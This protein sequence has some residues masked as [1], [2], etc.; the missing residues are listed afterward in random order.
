MLAEARRR[1]SCD[2]LL[3]EGDMRSFSLDRRFD[4]VICLF[5]SIGYMSSV[6]ELCRAANTMAE[7]LAPGGILVLDGWVRP[8]NWIEPGTV[9]VVLAEKDGL[10]VVR[11][12]RSRREGKVALLEMHHLV[13]TV[14]GIDHLVD[15]HA[16]TLFTPTEYEGALA[17]A[18]LGF[19]VM[20]SP[21]PGRDRYVA[22]RRT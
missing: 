6:E 12:G 1:L 22:R 21:M 9:H 19:E 8:D 3:A 10:K 17:G 20:E 7:H 15:D 16:L 2:V 14:E 18:G 4:A 5:S 13:V 11:A